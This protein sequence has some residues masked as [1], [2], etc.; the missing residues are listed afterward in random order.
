MVKQAL[1]STRSA[2]IW[3]FQDSTKEKGSKHVKLMLLIKWN[4]K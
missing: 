4:C 1:F 2:G 3:D